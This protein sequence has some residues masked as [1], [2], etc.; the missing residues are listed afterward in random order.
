MGA[1]WSPLPGL[2]L[3]GTF[4][5]SFKAPILGDLV[6]GSSSFS[7]LIDLI[8]EDPASPSGFTNIIA[9][10]GNNSDLGPE[11]AR[12]WTV[13]FEFDPEWLSGFHIEATYFDIEIKNRVRNAVNVLFT[14]LK[15]EGRFAPR[16]TRNPDPEAVQALFNDPNFRNIFGS[17]PEDIG[18]IVDFRLKN[19]GKIRTEGIDLT[20]S[21]GFDTDFGRFDFAINVSLFTQFKQSETPTAPLFDILDTV[22]N[23]ADWRMRD[24]VSW[25]RNGFSATAFVNYVDNMTDNE[26]TPA[27]KVNSWATIDLQLAY[28]TGENAASPWLRHLVFSISVQN[29]LDDDPPFFNNNNPNAA[30]GFDPQNASAL[31]RFVA[32]QLTKKF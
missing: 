6:T 13:G 1:V 14:I 23:P 19:I 11:E 15:Q 8:V 3:R 30:L 32:F 7:S 18:A 29:L 10:V 24:S 2:D 21:Y 22:R 26:S 9:L 20:A 12:S 27:R 5:T 25:S 4:G 16:I 17:R 31:N 28:D